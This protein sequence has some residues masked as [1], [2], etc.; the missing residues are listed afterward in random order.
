MPIDSAGPRVTDSKSIAL[1]A[2][3]SHENRRRFRILAG[4]LF[5]LGLLFAPSGAVA[6]PRHS[7]NIVSGIAAFR[8]HIDHIVFLEQEN[9]AFDNFFGTYCPAT[10]PRCPDAADGLP[11]GTCV[12]TN[13]AT[14]SSPCVAPYN[15]TARQLVISDLPHNWNSTHTAWNGGLM[16]GF[17]GAE[18]NR[19][20]TFGHYNGTTIPDYWDL[21]EEYGLADDFFS[22]SATFSL[23]NHWYAV[24]ATAPNES[25]TVKVENVGIP[26]SRLFTYLNESNATP[27]V[28]DSLLRSSTSWVDYD[29]PLG[30]YSNFT[31]PHSNAQ[32]YSYWNPLAARAQSYLAKSR[33]HFESRNQFFVDARN[34]SLPNLSWLIPLP[35]ESDHPPASL[36]TGQDWVTSVVD[37]VESSPEWNSTVLFIS[38]DEYGGFYDHVAPP[39]L[40]A[41][42]DG[43]RVPLLAIG[44]WVRQGAINH[45][46]MDFGSI[47]HLMEARFNLSCLG[48]R[49]CNATMPLNLFDFSRGP[50]APLFLP[51]YPNAAYAMPLQ[52]SGK[53]PPYGPWDTPPPP[54]GVEIPPVGVTDWS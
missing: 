1:A 42:G 19:T 53:L 4:V 54:P 5:T 48:V 2:L 31:Q 28:E 16:K 26:A 35:F 46:A 39:Q 41:Y 44:P 8:N 43:F 37:A 29:F 17:Y 7:V 40:D 22:S 18:L 27:S 20:E 15:L 24:A 21:A 32:A 49:D 34:G 30:K 23:A 52:T 51:Q 25:Y 11:S 3:R 36:A 14:N 47:L 38:W 33:P 9:H 6:N 12:P 10:G 45:H 50:R 13:P